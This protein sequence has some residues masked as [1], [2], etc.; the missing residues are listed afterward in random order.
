MREEEVKRGG[1]KVGH[2]GGRR[3]A[4]FYGWREMKLWCLG[5]T[6]CNSALSD[7]HHTLHMMHWSCREWNSHSHERSN[8]SLHC[9][10]S[11]CVIQMQYVQLRASHHHVMS[12]R[13]QLRHN[14]E[15]KWAQFFIFIFIVQYHTLVRRRARRFSGS[16][17]ISL[18]KKSRLATVCVLC[19]VFVD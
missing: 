9:A 4:A 7:A 15:E 18:K 13:Y 11:L 6:W 17:A 3:S 2:M 8:Q 14:R 5:C 1:N 10:K 16:L 12:L 19:C